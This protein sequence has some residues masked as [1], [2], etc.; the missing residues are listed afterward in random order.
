M[1]NIPD[2]ERL[3]NYITNKEPFTEMYECGRRG[4]YSD[5]E[6]ELNRMIDSGDF[7]NCKRLIK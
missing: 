1:D 2:A 4:D 5:I 6:A 7:E 3:M